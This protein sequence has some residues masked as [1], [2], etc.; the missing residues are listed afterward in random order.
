MFI[1]WD[2]KLQDQKAEKFREYVSSTNRTTNLKQYWTKIRAI[3]KSKDP[4][5]NPP[6]KISLDGKIPSEMETAMKLVC[7]YA[8][9]SK[10]KP[11]REDRR[12]VRSTKSSKIVSS[13]FNPFTKADVRN[14]IA[15]S[16]NT[17]ACGP[18]GISIYHLRNLGEK[19]LQL[20]TNIYNHSWLYNQIPPIWKKG[21]IIPILK[22]G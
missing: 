12:I 11:K 13:Q 6:P 3:Q 16:K 14:A 17:S 8:E 5:P 18:D 2:K 21:L 9:V 1:R 20:L 4:E 7:Y 15:S 10:G 19:G 22:P